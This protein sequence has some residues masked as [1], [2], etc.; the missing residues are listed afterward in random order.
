MWDTTTSDW[1]TGSVNQAW[2][3]SG[4]AVF[5]GV[6][7]N[8][9]LSTEF[10]VVNSITFN[11]SGYTIENGGI[12]AGAN[13]LTITTNADAAVSSTL[14]QDP[15]GSGYFLVKNG[16]GT[17]TMSGTNTFA[18]I[19]LDQGGYDAVG[20][21]SLSS[22][23]VVLGNAAG[24]TLTL[25]GTSES[26]QGVAG[27]GTIGG[28]V[29]PGAS[30]SVT[31]T[32]F[33]GGTFGG[34]LQDNGTN[35]LSIHFDGAGTKLTN[36][37][38]YSGPTTVLSGLTLSGSGSALNTTFTLDGSLTLDN[39]TVANAHRIS[40]NA[41]INMV[42]GQLYLNGN[43]ATTIEEAVGSLEISGQ[44]NVA[45]STTGS[46][47]PLLDF[48]GLTRNPGATL[49]I[50]STG[51][52]IT[53]LSNNSDGILPA[54]IFV[55]SSTS[56]AGLDWGTVGT[57]GR[58][59]AYSAYVSAFAGGS[60]TDNVL[61][62]TSGTT[63][64]GASAT[65][66]SL[67]LEPNGDS[68][69]I[70]LGA[71]Q[72]LDLSTGGILSS[73]GGPDGGPY[74][75]STIQDGSLTTTAPEWVISDNNS[76]TIN[77]A[78]LESGSAT[79]L[80]KSGFGT[81]T[82]TGSNTYAGITSIAQGTLAVA[83]DSN[84]GAGSTVQFG[85]GESGL[86]VLQAAGNFSSTKGFTGLP[87]SGGVIDTAGF[88]I[89]F[90]GPNATFLVKEGTGTLNLN[91]PATGGIEVTAGVVNLTAATSGTTFLQ[92]GTLL[93]SGT[94][95]FLGS[96]GDSST[97]DLAH[98]VTGRLVTQSVSALPIANDPSNFQLTINFGVGGSNSDLWTIQQIDLSQ[99]V[100]GSML[101]DF[102]N[103]GGVQ[104]GVNYPLLDLPGNTSLPVNDPFAFAPDMAAAGWA[105]TITSS[106]TS[107]SVNFTSV[108]TSVPEPGT[109]ALLAAAAAAV[110]PGMRRGGR[111]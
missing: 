76:L 77:S 63:T 42:G 13:G 8:V 33:G 45:T 60:T 92:V 80:T 104:T 29:E 5:E 10:P 105:G 53:S 54:Y 23:V 68:Q 52:S 101:F 2:E 14:D 82:L 98:S 6:A 50:T 94:L 26:I 59:T 39:S 109:W 46:R 49:T 79:A 100:A 57:N 56:A 86:A 73:G 55:A 18:E 1:W 67:N 36:A 85:G 58:I 44:S 69:V 41:P 90:S 61:I 102:V 47:T 87:G 16:A 88:N 83:S 106:G 43:S 40:S 65:R 78:I 111:P 9:S 108:P 110:A 74:T 4:D 28:I 38:T 21:A 95:S 35:Q 32:D 64:L 7:G 11:T 62:T 93:A 91:N 84:L 12:V 107:V 19:E 31:L 3:A 70:D 96:G 48:A 75:S 34:V 20:N 37:N 30:S 89:A 72:S 71:D 99:L 66:A 25:D 51:T 15:G 27:G 24:V 97:L 103:L 22:S 17:L 81:L